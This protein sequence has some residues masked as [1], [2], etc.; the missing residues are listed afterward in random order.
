[1]VFL[2]RTENIDF[3]GL[4]NSPWFKVA[5]SLLPKD[6]WGRSVVMLISYLLLWCNY[7]ATNDVSVLCA[8]SFSGNIFWSN[9]LLCCLLFSELVC[10][11][12][13]LCTRRIVSICNTG[14]LFD[15]VICFLYL[16]NFWSWFMFSTLYH[17][18]F[19]NKFNVGYFSAAC[20]LSI[21]YLFR[22]LFL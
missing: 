21:R 11:H 1:M 17:N 13:S 3:S 6:D 16:L 2:T 20:F 15:H 10:L 18:V 22:P 9:I 4:Y 19:N 5:D 7:P 14:N 8:A 12:R